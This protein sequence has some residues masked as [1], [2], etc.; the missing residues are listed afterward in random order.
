MKNDHPFYHFPKKIVGDCSASPY[1][2][3]DYYDEPLGD[4]SIIPTY[5][6]CQQAKK[7]VTVALSGD[8]GDELFGGYNWYSQFRSIIK[9]GPIRH[10][11]APLLALLGGRGMILGKAGNPFELYR[12]L[13]SPRFEL[14][15]IKALFPL[16]REDEFPESANF[17]LERYYRPNL[18]PIKRWQ[19]IDAMTFMVDDILTKVDRASMANSLEVRVPFLDHRI[20]EFAFSLPDKLC[21]NRG[22]KKYIV[23]RFLEKHVPVEI[24]SKPKQG[25]SCPVTTYWPPEKMISDVNAG[26]LIKSGIIDKTA[27][28]NLCM[29]NGKS[30]GDAKIWLIAVLEKWSEKWLVG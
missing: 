26:T 7:Y 2:L 6:L 20:V 8:G 3:F 12:Q 14:D 19:Y 27:W 28:S 17:L 29:E 30:I 18:P 25:F 9:F 11:I 23:R 5:L 4:S 24:L 10:F 22:R 15:G 21:L 13:T 1:E 16:A